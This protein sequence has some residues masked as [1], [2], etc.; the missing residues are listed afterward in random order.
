MI[1]GFR[2]KGLER[3]YQSG[4]KRGIVADQAKRLRH[5]LAALE[6]ASSPKDLNLPGFRPHRLK[7]DLEGH[8]AITVSGN[9][10]VVSRFNEDN[11]EAVDYVDYH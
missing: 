5:I 7:G 9:W 3:F 10:R 6:A 1:Q 8:W 11:V 4:S 2:H